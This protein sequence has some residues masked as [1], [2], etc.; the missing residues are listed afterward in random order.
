MGQAG[1]SAGSVSLLYGDKGGKV[2]KIQNE[3]HAR[4][5]PG[6]APRF[7][8]PSQTRKRHPPEVTSLHSAALRT[9]P[10]TCARARGVAERYRPPRPPGGALS[11]RQTRDPAP[12]KPRPGS[13]VCGKE[14]TVWMLLIETLEPKTVLYQLGDRAG[15]KGPKVSRLGILASA[16]ARGRMQS[17]LKSGV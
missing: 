12:R 7:G 8:A 6:G 10:G 9:S 1:A 15:H 4:E 16:L 14:R 11:T 2:T 13:A 5:A 17:C 3:I